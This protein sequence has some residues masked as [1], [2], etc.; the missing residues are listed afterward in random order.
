MALELWAET[1][2][3]KNPR[4]F[5]DMPCVLP[6]DQLGA[7][8][9]REED[10]KEYRIWMPIMAYSD[11]IRFYVLYRCIDAD[12]PHVGKFKKLT[13][14]SASGNIELDDLD[15]AKARSWYERCKTR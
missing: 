4:S 1:Y 8:E 2:G 9:L 11:G 15:D 10:C 6:N 12:S 14:W 13:V 5:D 3:V 7:W